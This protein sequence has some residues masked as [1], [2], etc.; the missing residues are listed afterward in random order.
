MNLKI[1]IAIFLLVISLAIGIIIGHFGIK[2]KNQST[3]P[4]YQELIAQVDPKV[5]F[6]LL[7]KELNKENIRNHLKYEIFKKILSSLLNHV[8]LFCLNK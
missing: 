6:D 1:P 5:G 7:E 2:S 3:D 8:K 4:Y